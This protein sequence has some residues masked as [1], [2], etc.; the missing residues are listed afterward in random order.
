MHLNMNIQPVNL[1]SSITIQLKDKIR[2]RWMF[3]KEHLDLQF[4]IKQC[5][6]WYSLN[7]TG[8]TQYLAD[9]A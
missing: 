2:A 1:P 3:A 9:S 6:N 5:S 8:L 4:M 7:K